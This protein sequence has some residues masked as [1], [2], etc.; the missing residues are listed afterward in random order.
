MDPSRI[1]QALYTVA[2][3]RALDRRATDTFD[4]PGIE[5]MRRAARA[6]LDALRRH[7]P[8]AQRLAV[9]CGPGNN[10]GDGFL[11]AVLA[12]EAGLEVQVVALSDAAHGDALKA[13]EQLDAAG[14]PRTLFA[15]DM[16]QPEV[17]VH[18]DALFGSGLDRAPEGD[19]AALIRRINEGDAP[20]LA[21]DVP[22]G[23]NAG[24]GHCP[25]VAMVAAVTVSFI[26]HKRGL[27]TGAAADHVGMLELD[28]L[29]LPQ[30]LW[31]QSPPDAWLLEPQSLPR[32][33]RSAHKGNNGTVLA[34]GGDHGTA[35]AIRLCG[36]A[37]L[38]MGAGKVVLA[39]R[40]DNLGALQA[41]RAEWMPH[42]VDQ[43]D[44]LSPLIEMA[45]VLA[46]GPGLGKGDWSH[47]LW[48]MAL[49]S[50]TPMVID[51]DA[52]NLLAREPR[53]LG[54][55]AVL[56]PHPGEAAR[57]L[58]CKTAEIEQDRYAALRQLAD[59]YGAVV[60]LKGAGSLIGDAHGR[61]AVCPWGNPGMASGGMGD[62][63]TGVIAALLAQKLEPWEAA[64]M[65]VGL[66]ARAGDA[67]AR[68]GERGL[69]AGDLL[70]WLRSLG[71]DVH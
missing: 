19:A 50:H 40:Q 60:V 44:A 16:P 55:P 10:G 66:H 65:G 46:L 9:W 24:A 31:A 67:A 41:A 69:L 56:T 42:A 2:Q 14:I 52:L 48:Q 57:L 27:H 53:R 28:T 33:P 36:E 26:A 47:A 6:A 23:L 54:Q 15:P 62:L 68:D 29:G 7:W 51:A 37:A 4:I 30:A 58:D 49:A 1:Y 35:G 17:D 71:N 70:P 22:S 8:K 43:V 59:R 21:L 12:A 38:R 45:S 61:V 63:L 25:G 32:R 18:V 20:V 5:L 39:T 11:F 34:I 13:R 3:T 64:C